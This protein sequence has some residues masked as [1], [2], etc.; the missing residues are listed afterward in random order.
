MVAIFLYGYWVSKQAIK[1]LGSLKELLR[2]KGNMQEQFEDFC[3]W[4]HKLRVVFL[5][6]PI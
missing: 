3:L 6:Y 2:G 5:I 1:M 4:I